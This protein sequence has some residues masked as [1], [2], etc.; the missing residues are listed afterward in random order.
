MFCFSEIVL[1]QFCFR[2]NHCFTTTR[3]TLRHTPKKYTINVYVTSA[4][5]AVKMAELNRTQCQRLKAFVQPH[6]D[7]DKELRY[8]HI[9][10]LN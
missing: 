7:R 3:A 8:L 5:Q 9:E 2:F 4:L 1:F 10:L 6:S